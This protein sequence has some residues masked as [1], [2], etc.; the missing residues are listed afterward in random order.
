LTSICSLT[1][2]DRPNGMREHPSDPSRPI[3]QSYGKRLTGISETEQ[4]EEK[5]SG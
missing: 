1:N 2:R 3:R 5:Q 4:N